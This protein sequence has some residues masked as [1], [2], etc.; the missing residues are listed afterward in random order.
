MLES[1]A[2]ASAPKQTASH[3][4]SPLS[5][6][7]KASLLLEST[8]GVNVIDGQ[9]QMPLFLAADN[10]NQDVVGLSPKSGADTNI[11]EEDGH[12]PLSCGRLW[13]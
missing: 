2:D 4:A 3:I 7:I 6:G 12:T 11:G 9:M 5:M 1:A 8:A 13:F 10:G